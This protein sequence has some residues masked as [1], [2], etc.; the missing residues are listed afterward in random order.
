MLCHLC[1]R[2]DG[3]AP[4]SGPIAPAPGADFVH[5]CDPEQL[6]SVRTRHFG[7]GAVWVISIDP[8]ALDPAALIRED[9]YGHGVFPHYY[10]TIPAEARRGHRALP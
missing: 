1:P 10:G 2:D 8:E 4:P 7:G 3:A 9:S 6:E 5:L